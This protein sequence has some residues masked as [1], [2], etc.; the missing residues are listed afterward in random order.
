MKRPLVRS[1]STDLHETDNAYLGEGGPAVVHRGE[2]FE[3]DV[4]VVEEAR[5][6][7]VDNGVD[8]GNR[9]SFLAGRCGTPLLHR[10][11]CEHVEGL[12]HRIELGEGDQAVGFRKLVEVS[13]VSAIHLADGT[14]PLVKRSAEVLV[15]EDGSSGA[16]IVVAA[17]Q[18]VLDAQPENSELDGGVD[19]VV[20]GLG[21]VAEV[22]DGED[23]SRV[24]A[25]D[26]GL[27]HARV[28]GANPHDLGHL[29][30]AE[31]VHERPVVR[32][33]VLRPLL[34][35]GEKLRDLRSLVVF[36]RPHTSEGPAV[37]SSDSRRNG[38]PAR[39]A[40]QGGRR[41]SFGRRPG[42]QGGSPDGDGERESKL[43][44]GGR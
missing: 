18:D 26:H 12:L 40:P 41:G 36:P 9:P 44:A 3:I 17:N 5:G 10:R 21:L 4:H 15:A 7:V 6:R 33:H 14:H 37:S 27:R 35:A 20:G 42:A 16:A 11:R 24:H 28:R 2:P 29:G 43:H 22:A 31:E 8:A 32:I 39:D 19:R 23:L 34:V 25:G 1:P 13:F 38:V 30:R